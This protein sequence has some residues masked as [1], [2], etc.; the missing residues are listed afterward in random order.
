M[1]AVKSNDAMAQRYF[2]FSISTHSE[3][4]YL[5]ATECCAD[6]LLTRSNS[7][8]VF[9]DLSRNK[10]SDNVLAP[11]SYSENLKCAVVCPVYSIHGSTVFGVLH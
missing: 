8:T 5:L 10:L 3:K 7:D 6:Y 4:N 2:R 11:I 9:S 1:F